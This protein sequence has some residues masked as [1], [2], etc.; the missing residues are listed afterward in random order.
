MFVGGVVGGG[1]CGVGC[2]VDVGVG[3]YDYVVFCVVEGLYVFVGS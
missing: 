1:D 3:Y 2:C